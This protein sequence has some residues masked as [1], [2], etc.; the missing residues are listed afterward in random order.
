MWIPNLESTTDYTVTI[1][2][3]SVSYYDLE[4]DESKVVFEKQF[5]DGELAVSF[6]TGVPTAI[7]GVNAGAKANRKVRVNGQI[8]IIKNGQK[9]TVSGVTLK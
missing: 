5:Q 2:S 7:E 1:N 9:S 3:V 4:T 8:M 6:N